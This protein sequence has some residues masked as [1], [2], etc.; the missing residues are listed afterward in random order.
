[1]S[2]LKC[3]F[4]DF[5]ADEDEWNDDHTNPDEDSEF[6]CPQCQEKLDF[7]DLEEPDEPVEA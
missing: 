4:C 3:C 7:D 5:S 2:Q 6:I 1:M